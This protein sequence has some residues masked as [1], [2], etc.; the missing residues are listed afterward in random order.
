[1]KKYFTK[2]NEQTVWEGWPNGIMD[3]DEFVDKGYLQEVNRLFFHPRGLILTVCTWT[4]DNDGKELEKPTNLLFI[5]DYREE[6]DGVIFGIDDMT[7]EEKAPFIRKQ[8]IIDEITK[9][10]YK[11]R[12][13][14]LGYPIEVITVE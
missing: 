10:N 12:D 2:E 13:K 1:M 5:Y 8:K 9:Q 6:K 11:D 4:K 7:D 14:T 3:L